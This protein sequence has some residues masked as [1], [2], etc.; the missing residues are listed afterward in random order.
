MDIAFEILLPISDNLSFFQFKQ[1]EYEWQGCK[2]PQGP[3]ECS[4]Y[5]F[6]LKKLPIPSHRLAMLPEYC[7]TIPWQCISIFGDGLYILKNGLSE[8][9]RRDVEAQLLGLLNALLS[10]KSKW[11]VVFEPDYDRLDEV[12]KGEIEEV[13]EKIKASLLVEKRGFII[14]RFES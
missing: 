4:F 2:Y 7:R 14:W 5:S 8:G 6:I 3:P 1:P 10:N 12:K 11:V 9:G 13:F